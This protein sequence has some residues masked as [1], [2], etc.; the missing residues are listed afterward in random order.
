M[1]ESVK[2]NM[3]VCNQL[4]GSYLLLRRMIIMLYLLFSGS[5]V[6]IVFLS[7]QS[8]DALL[9]GVLLN[10]ILLAIVMLVD[11]M[12]FL[13]KHF[14]LK[15]LS[16]CPSLSYEQL[17][18]A[19]SLLEEDYHTLLQRSYSERREL[20]TRMDNR[21]EDI[22]DYYT[23]WTHQIKT[24][25]AAMKLLLEDDQTMAASQAKRELTKMENYVTSAL[26]YARLDEITTDF[27][28]EAIELDE[29]VKPLLKKYAT[30]FISK[31]LTLNYEPLNVLA[32]TDL[33]WLAFILDQVLSNALKYTHEGS[34]HI[35]MDQWQECS[36]VIED[37]GIGINPEDL[38]RIF[39]RGFTGY[40]GH[41]DRKS[42]G[43]GLY[44]T[45]EIANRLSHRITVVS[46]PDRGTTVTVHLT[47]I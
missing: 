20:I 27:S 8:L 11:F 12:R 36:L 34:I 13:K 43:I 46:E 19:D 10:T 37:T 6:G 7:R 33:K 29:V 9:Y 32:L 5:L 24:P 31:R 15:D 14:R 47:P 44:L 1:R 21:M 25:I 30:F 26:A 45:K 16:D 40:N 42:T 39:E 4:A 22:R 41:L 17:P 23:L 2:T 35:Y 3:L 38:P 18:Q 28:F